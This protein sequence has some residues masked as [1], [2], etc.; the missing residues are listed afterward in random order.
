MCLLRKQQKKDINY[1][2][3]RY[4]LFVWLWKSYEGTRAYM[5]SHWKQLLKDK[6]SSKTAQLHP[7]TMKYIRAAQK[8][9]SSILLC[10]PRTSEVNVGG[11]AVEVE[12]FHQYSIT[13]CCCETDG[14]R[15][16][17]WQNGVWHGGAYEAKVCHWVPLYGKNGT[18]WHS[19]ILTGCLWRP[20][21]GC[22][23]SE[24]VSG[25]FQQCVIS[26]GADF[27]ECDMQAL[28]HHWWKCTANGGDFV[29]K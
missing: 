20:D 17:A 12:L 7:V 14:S 22:E 25:V 21:S 23:H 16:A 11:K 5:E 29:E 10:W 6:Y 9:M 18:H 3:V 24:A 13:F 27:Y 26:A 1:K 19:L 28:V 2:T 4:N 8:I 15:G